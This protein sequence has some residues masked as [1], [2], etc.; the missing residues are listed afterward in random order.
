MNKAKMFL[1]VAAL[2]VASTAMA[3]EMVPN[4]L[5]TA[6]VGE[7]AVYKLPDGYIQKQTVLSRD[8]SGPEAMVTV[9]IEDI[10]NKE[11]VNTREI[12]IPAGEPMT[13]PRLPEGRNLEIGVDRKDTDVLGKT[14]NVTIIEVEDKDAADDEADDTEWWVS[15]EITVFGIVKKY[16]EDKLD[17]EIIAFGEE[18]NDSIDF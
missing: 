5:A 9:R 8:G 4:R 11:V 6:K 13:L 18:P 3:E 17:F 12:S 14:Y 10:Y 15:S 7:W 1:V 16:T 2:L